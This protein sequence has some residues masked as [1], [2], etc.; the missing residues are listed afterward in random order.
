MTRTSLPWGLVSLVA[1][2][3]LWV[4]MGPLPPA[5]LSVDGEGGE[6]KMEGVP[7][8]GSPRI[9]P[10]LAAPPAAGGRPS[11]LLITIDTLRPDALG[12]VAGRNETP[13]IDGLAGEGFR[14]SGAVSQVPITL[15]SHTSILSGL[16]P[17]RHG[18]RDNGQMVAGSFPLLSERLRDAG[19][20]TAAFV[21]GY[22]LE[23]RFGLDR[24]FSHY[25]DTLPEGQQGWVERRAEG[26]TKAA[27]D[28]LAKQQEPFF[29]WVHFYDPHDP[30]DPPRVFWQPGPR[31]GYDGEV[32]YV[33]HWVGQLFAGAKS[34]APAGL[35]T[36]LGAD[37]GEGL[38]EHRENTHGYFV[39][40]STVLVP[41]LFHFPGRI[42]PG[43]SKAPIRLVDIAPTVLE[44][45]GAKALGDVDGISW[46][47]TLE[48][49]NQEAPGAYVETQ[50][51]WR[52][53]GWSPL[54]AWRRPDWKLIVAP[55]PELYRPDLDPHEAKNLY[56]EERRQ[57]GRLAAELAEVKKRPTLASENAQDPEV[58]EKLRALGYVGAGGGQGAIPRGLPDPKDRIAER[59]LLLEG[60][61]LLRAGKPADA[62]ALFEKVLAREPNDR[63]ATLR[64][65]IVL[66][67]MGRLEEAVIRLQKAVK[68]DPDRAEA[69]YALADALTRSGQPA[70]AAQEWME[71]ARL[72]PRRKEPWVNMAG[73]LLAT[74][75][76]DKAA[77]ALAR[78]LELDPE[79]RKQLESDPKLAPLLPRRP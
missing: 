59:I 76:K 37:H 6:P 8:S 24:G 69:R 31:G 15:P 30:Y 43:E 74:G 27:L 11:V 56:D 79:L 53:F 3:L 2:A 40:D 70:R 45:L 28:W 29:A 23:A 52:F 65:G 44:L 12:W 19:Y 58:T 7:P 25:D 63:Y 16:Y 55:R 77:A 41:L 48:G 38:G 36:V 61:A 71:V 72:Q 68:A 9:F 57:A 73:T 47:K 50:L 60:E 64:S 66:L 35:L 62:L 34:K 26:T 5:P 33:D 17:P 10:A 13:A 21:S 18:V 51:P 75:Q 1:G 39:Y 46:L 20:A 42:A 4:A 49:G 67:G 22:P 14:F 78:A 54:E 32:T